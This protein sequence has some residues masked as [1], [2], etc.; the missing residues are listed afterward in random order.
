MPTVYTF[1]ADTMCPSPDNE[2]LFL[3]NTASDL[4]GKISDMSLSYTT[5]LDIGAAIGLKALSPDMKGHLK[6]DMQSK[7]PAAYTDETLK[8]LIIMTD[9]EATAQ[10]RPYDGCSSIGKVWISTGYN[11][12][13]WK[14]CSYTKYSASTARSNFA[15][16][17]DVARDN[18]IAVFT[19]GFQVDKGAN[20]DKIL[21]ACA[22][23]SS[24]YYYIEDTDI[25][26]AFKSIAASINSVRLT[27]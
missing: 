26:T 8:V 9:G 23:S 13:Y 6:G 3:S 11:S 12:G 7:H 20:S 27:M 25:A 22:T 15:D 2:A 17:C 14:Q 19:I 10:D 16:V 18:G 21:N 5:G 1:G 24:Q 4:K